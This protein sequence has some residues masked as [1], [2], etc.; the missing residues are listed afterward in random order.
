MLIS[1]SGT[2]CSRSGHGK[3][4]WQMHSFPDAVPGWRDI[5][6]VFGERM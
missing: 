3:T 4:E 1:A 5:M 6:P 2:L